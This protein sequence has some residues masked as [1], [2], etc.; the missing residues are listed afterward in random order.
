[1]A[2]GGADTSGNSSATM[3]LANTTSVTNMGSGTSASG[4]ASALGQEGDNLLLISA[5]TVDAAGGANSGATSAV[6]DQTGVLDVSDVG[7]ARTGNSTAIGIGLSNTFVQNIGGGVG[8]VVNV[9]SITNAGTANASTGLAS[10]AGQIGNNTLEVSVLTVDAAGGAN[11]GQTS[12]V[13][14]Q[15]ADEEV[16]NGALVTTGNAVAAGILEANVEVVSEQPDTCTTGGAKN[17]GNTSCGGSPA[18][19]PGVSPSPSASSAASAS[20]SPSASA[21]SEVVPS[22]PPSPPSGNQSNTGGPPPPPGG[23]GTQGNLPGPSPTGSGPSPQGETALPPLGSTATPPSPSAGP[24]GPAPAIS[25]E[26]LGGGGMRTSFGLGTLLIPVG[27]ST[28]VSALRRKKRQQGGA[29]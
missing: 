23:Q 2:T 16:Q 4:G 14:T 12:A 25:I 29:E 21:S 24:S 17:G 26:A 13:N 1:V 19:G 11:S 7:A 3:S 20:P 5:G 22:S 10:A 9:V 18:A 6:N 28:L 8:S 15:N 27:L